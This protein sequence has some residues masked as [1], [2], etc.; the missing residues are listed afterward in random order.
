[1]GASL[2]LTA[3]Q[4]EDFWTNIDRTGDCWTWRPRWKRW[5]IV[6]GVQLTP[7]VCAWAIAGKPLPDQGQYLC[8]TCRNRACVRHLVLTSWS[9]GQPSPPRDKGV[10]PAETRA[11][12]S[13]SRRKHEGRMNARS[14]D[15][16][17]GKL[18]RTQALDALKSKD[19]LTSA[20]KRLGVSRT[21]IWR[22][23]KRITWQQ[24]R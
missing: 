12:I 5:R 4:V 10:M 21:A 23:R 2:V 24:L 22:I 3:S 13:A 18:T 1:M 6:P 19:P 15:H 8:V 20:A 14:E 7:R 17:R 9:G 16:G 11:K